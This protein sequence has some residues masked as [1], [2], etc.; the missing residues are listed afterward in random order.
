MIEQEVLVDEYFFNSS[1]HKAYMS[2]KK[3]TFV[4]FGV[5]VTFQGKL[6][7][8]LVYRFS[9]HS[10]SEMPMFNQQEIG[11]LYDGGAGTLVCMILMRPTYW[12]MASLESY[13]E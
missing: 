10:Y 9:A 3:G 1:C 6:H 7:S 8:H 13:Y 2:L 11:W 4:I 12:P 5:Y